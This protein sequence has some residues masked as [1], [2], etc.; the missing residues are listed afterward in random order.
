MQAQMEYSKAI[1]INRKY[2]NRQGVTIGPIPLL[3][4]VCPLIGYRTKCS[5]SSDK[6]QITM[7][8]S[9]QAFSL[10]V[11][12]NNIHIYQIINLN[13]FNFLKRFM[14]YFQIND[15]VFASSSTLLFMYGLCATD[16]K[17]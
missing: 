11:T 10:S 1:N 4:Y 6:C 5:S 2:E 16:N 3:L 15:P 7:C 8:F 17:R 13:Y 9:N 14:I 12:N